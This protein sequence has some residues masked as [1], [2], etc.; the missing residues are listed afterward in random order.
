MYGGI[1]APVF[2]DDFVRKLRELVLW[3]RD[4]RRF[5]PHRLPSGHLERLIETACLS[6]S[7]GLSEPW[8]FVIVDDL[9]R[10]TEVRNNFSATNA[11]ALAGYEG[12][13]ASRYASLKL[14]GLDEAPCQVGV[15]VDRDTE[16][17]H[18]LGSRTMPETYEYSAVAAIQTLWILAR[19]EGVG[20]GWV[21]ILDPVSLKATLD[22]PPGWHFVAYLCLGYPQD[23]D[24]VPSL[25]RAGWERR[26]SPKSVIWHR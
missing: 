18:G 24:D 23:E 9:S 14:A 26:H 6:P 12:Q 21:S 13:R 4:V 17:G 11:S 3:R 2:D 15:F 1:S 10:R 19:A 16:K 20:V 5:R 25:Q 8:R 22:I 7:V